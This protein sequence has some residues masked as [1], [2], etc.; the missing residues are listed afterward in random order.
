MIK[1]IKAPRVNS[2]PTTAININP[3]CKFNRRPM[4]LLYCVS[5]VC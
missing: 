1:A 3:G 2:V 4:I 5:Q